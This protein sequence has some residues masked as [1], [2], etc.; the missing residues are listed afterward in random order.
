MIYTLI[1]IFIHSLIAVFALI[2]CFFRKM[3]YRKMFKKH[4]EARTSR[5]FQELN[6]ARILYRRAIITTI[7]TIAAEI[8]NA[9]ILYMAGLFDILY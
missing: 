9:F 2:T 8:A 7:V 6:R 5:W 1:Y 3:E 4:S